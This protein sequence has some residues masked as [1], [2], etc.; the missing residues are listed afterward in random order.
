MYLL[1]SNIIIYASKEEYAYLRDFFTNQEVPSFA[2]VISKVEVLGYYKLTEIDKLFFNACFSLLETIEVNHAVAEKAIAIRQ[3][4]KLSL[5]DA[6]I[7]A[8][9]LIYGYTIV[10]RNVDDFKNISGLIVVN[11]IH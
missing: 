11:P 7:A 4:L 5:G 2:S 3:E 1:D 10:T 6:I 9:A 8:T